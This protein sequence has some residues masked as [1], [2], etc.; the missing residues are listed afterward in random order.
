MDTANELGTSMMVDIEDPSLRQA[1]G[2]RK[3][4]DSK[5]NVIASKLFTS[6]TFC[7]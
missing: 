1:K 2:V 7:L 3:H 6:L 5:L 4:I